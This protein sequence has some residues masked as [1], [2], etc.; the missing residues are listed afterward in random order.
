MWTFKWEW[1]IF[2]EIPGNW[3][4]A[5]WPVWHEPLPQ[6]SKIHFLW[7]RNTSLF[8]IFI[9]SFEKKPKKAGHYRLKH[10]QKR[11][12][13]ELRWDTNLK[14]FNA[15]L[16]GVSDMRYQYARCHERLRPGPNFIKHESKAN[17]CLAKFG[18]H[19][20]C[21][22]P[23][24]VKQPHLFLAWQRNLLSKCENVH[25]DLFANTGARA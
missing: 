24:A 22:F 10:K 3:L 19:P 21:R 1:I 16:W 4:Y 2:K 9:Q 17:P 25:I 13:K 12:L 8:K 7:V 15:S 5:N 23:I 6:N 11:A 14:M 18:Y 20:Y